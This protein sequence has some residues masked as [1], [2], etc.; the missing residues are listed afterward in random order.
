MQGRFPHQRLLANNSLADHQACKWAM[1][2]TGTTSLERRLFEQLSGGERQRGWIAM[3]LAQKTKYLLLDG[4]NTFL[5]IGHQLE[6][7]R[8]L[9]RLNQTNSITLI[10]V[11]HEINHACQF[12]DQLIVLR[13]GRLVS[14][15]PPNDI[16][17]ADLLH[18]VFQVNAEVIKRQQKGHRF[19]YSI[20][21]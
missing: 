7:M 9:R 1:Q 16:M 4:P 12:A 17:S 2:V 15:G 11:L 3:V 13:E 6:I 21:T 19:P 10:I 14:Q 20:I 5:D 8:L 18:D